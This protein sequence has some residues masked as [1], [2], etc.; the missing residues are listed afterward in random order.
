LMEKLRAFLGRLR[1]AFAIAFPA[2]RGG[3]TRVLPVA[4][5]IEDGGAF[6]GLAGRPIKIAGHVMAGMA[7]E[8]DLFDR[9]AVAS[10]LAG[11]GRIERDFFRHGP[12][13][14]RDEELLLEDRLAGLP[15]FLRRGRVPGV[16]LDVV[17]PRLF[18]ETAVLFLRDERQRAEG[19]E[20]TGNEN[21]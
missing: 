12:H 6:A 13:A 16:I 20:Q 1:A 19:E 8:E 21:A 2:I 15:G 14:L 4:M 10:D 18:R 11:D 17:I 9:V 7:D 5:G 3:E